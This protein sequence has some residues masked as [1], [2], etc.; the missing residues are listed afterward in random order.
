[1]GYSWP[2]EDNPIEVPGGPYGRHGAVPC[3]AGMEKDHP[4]RRAARHIAGLRGL[5]SCGDAALA[6]LATMPWR[7]SS[8]R[9]VALRSEVSFIRAILHDSS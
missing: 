5:D 6:A 2:R 7:A 8:A 1:M 9:K 4:I 3:A